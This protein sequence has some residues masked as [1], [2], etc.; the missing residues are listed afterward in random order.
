MAA[1]S[2]AGN[3]IERQGMRFIRDPLNPSVAP[4]GEPSGHAVGVLQIA[5]E[6]PMPDEVIVNGVKYL[7]T[8]AA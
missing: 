3:Y 2:I 5:V 7:P 4:V 1:L 6:C 8:G